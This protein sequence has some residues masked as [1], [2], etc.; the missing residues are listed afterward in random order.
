MKN[1]DIENLERKNIFTTPDHFFD[2]MQEEVLRK[3]VHQEFSKKEE[4]KPGKIIP[5]NWVYAAAAALAL[6]FGLGYFLTSNS[7]TAVPQQTIAKVDEQ[8]VEPKSVV[9]HQTPQVIEKTIAEPVKKIETDLTLAKN[10]HPK[11]V[12]AKNT[13]PAK[14]ERAKNE[15]A[16]P[17]AKSTAKTAAFTATIPD[18]AMM[19][20]VLSSF[21]Y[22]E[23]KEASKNTEQ[24]VYLD[25][26]N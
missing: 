24:D 15:E 7:K 25:L 1:F 20:Q 14:I 21:T 16:I 19:D 2:K 17:V 23:L 4:Q 3:T 13:A 8:K 26:Y 22:A 18:E 12:V 5:F 6:I 9:E 10:N 11:V